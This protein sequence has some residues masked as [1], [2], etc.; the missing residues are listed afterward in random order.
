M[1]N[2]QNFPLVSVL[3]IT[4][5]SSKTV[6]ETLDSVY[7]QTYPNIELIVSDDCSPDNTVELVRE[8]VESH[9]DRFARVEVL[10]VEKNTGVSGNLNRAEAVCEGVWEKGIAGDDILMPNCIQD[11]IDY[12]TEHPD[13][14]WLFGRME[15]F[16]STDKEN[17]RVSAV[18]NYAFF[19]MSVVEQL[20]TLIFE[21][22]CL[23]APASFVHIQRNRELGVKNDERIPLLEDWPKWINLLRAGVKFQ[24]VDKLLVK[25][26]IGG[27][28][29]TLASMRYYRDNRLAYFYYTHYE[30]DK[31]NRE[32][33]IQKVVAHECEVYDRVLKLENEVKEIRSSKSY[34]IG[35]F[36]LTPLKWMAKRF[37]K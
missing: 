11:C 37:N 25:Y 5:N 13:T 22:N 26:R 1:M 14:I 15:A 8:W 12:V 24:F 19:E 7:N 4:Y 20:R 31:E 28:S 3:V 29:T 35:K 17:Q 2:K 36:V 30:I 32:M 9:E 16:G 27:I 23:P 6:I 34:R 10:T 21:G 18:F 33:A